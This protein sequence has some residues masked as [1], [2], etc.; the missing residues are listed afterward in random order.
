MVIPEFKRQ[1]DSLI[2]IDRNGKIINDKVI[3]DN[4][5]FT[6]HSKK[7]EYTP[8]QIH[9]LNQSNEFKKHCDSLG[10]YIHMIYCKNEILFNN[11]DIDKAKPTNSEFI[12]MIADKLRLEFQ[13]S[14]TR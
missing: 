2:R 10:G 11:V 6:I 13:K 9:F 1:Y 12:A 14:F 5:Y 8:Q 3:K 4:E 7:K